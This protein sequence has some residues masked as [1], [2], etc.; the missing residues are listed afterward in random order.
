[1]ITMN[2]I[3]KY[4]HSGEL[5]KIFD[6][7]QRDSRLFTNN[8]DEFFESE[9]RY[10]LKNTQIILQNDHIDWLDVI[11]AF[12]ADDMKAV[13]FKVLIGCIYKTIDE[14]EELFLF[15]DKRISEEELDIIPYFNYASKDIIEY[16]NNNIKVL[17]VK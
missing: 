16:Y 11:D 12:V 7:I 17:L 4:I 1:M 14:I 2:K 5:N 3:A 9:F 15:D 10:L 8:M 6:L 13:K